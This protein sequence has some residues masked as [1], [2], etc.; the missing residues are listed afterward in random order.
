[1]A[2]A[3]TTTLTFR[4]ESNLKGALRTAAAND[5]RSIT[6]MVAVM[7]REHCGRVTD[8]ANSETLFRVI[9]SIQSP[10]VEPLKRWLAKVGKERL[11]ELENPELAMG[12]MQEI[13]E[14]KG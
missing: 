13:Y 6:N 14:K 11:D 1:M 7:V 3:K 12:R 2:T 5:H 9:Q 4:I 10:K 8:C